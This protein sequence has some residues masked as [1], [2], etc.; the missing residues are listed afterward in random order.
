LQECE[1]CDNVKL[2]QETVQLSVDIEPGMTDGQVITVFEEGEPEADGD[3]GD[4]HFVVH[5]LPHHVFYRDGKHLHHAA[6]ITLLEA[7]TG[8]S[9]LAHLDGHRCELEHHVWGR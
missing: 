9:W 5:A 7:L 2:V 4:L 3:P 8:F 6:T 1:Q